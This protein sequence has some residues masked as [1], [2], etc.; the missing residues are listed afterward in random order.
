MMAIVAMSDMRTNIP[1]LRKSILL[2]N[3]M[4]GMP[5]KHIRYHDFANVYLIEIRGS[6]EMIVEMM[7][8]EKCINSTMKTG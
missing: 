5:T 3:K 7:I 8:H 4:R 2:L 1:S 6:F